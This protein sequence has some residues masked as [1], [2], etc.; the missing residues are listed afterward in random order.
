MEAVRPNR[1]R[2][3]QAIWASCDRFSRRAM[4]LSRAKSRSDLFVSCSVPA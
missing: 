4:I 1:L 3:S 2:I